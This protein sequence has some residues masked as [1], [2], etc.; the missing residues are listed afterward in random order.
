ML[1]YVNGELAATSARFDGSAMN[2]TNDAAPPFV[3]FDK[4]AAANR[5]WN[6]SLDDLRIYHHALDPS[7]VRKLYQLPSD[8]AAP[9]TKA[10]VTPDEPGGLNGWYTSDVTVELTAA[11]EESGVT[12]TEYRLDGGEWKAYEGAVHVS[13]EGITTLEYRSRDGAGNVEEVRNLTLAIDKSEPKLTITRTVTLFGR[14]T[15]NG[16][17]WR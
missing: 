2:V 4:G 10:A 9:V 16:C 12:G 8:A 3:G 13:A 7:D 5:D 11:D 1:I 15:A 17:Q 14:P 6:G